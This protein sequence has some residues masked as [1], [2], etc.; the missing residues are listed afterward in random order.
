[1]NP[2]GVGVLRIGISVHVVP[3]SSSQVRAFGQPLP[4][5][6]V[7]I[8]AEHRAVFGLYQCTDSAG[9]RR[10]GGDADSADESRRQARSAGQFGPRVTAI[11]AAP[12]A[13]VRTTTFGRVWIAPTLPDRGVQRSAV[14]R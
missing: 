9:L 12:D 3:G 7:V 8:R 11:G 4:G 1:E 13:R 6:T 14:A 5:L 2:D 10:G